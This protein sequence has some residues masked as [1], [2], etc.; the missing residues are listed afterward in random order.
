VIERGKSRVLHASYMAQDGGLGERSGSV[1]GA[2]IRSG[3]NATTA[4][5]PLIGP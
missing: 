5:I 4:K 1:R 3:L 2:G